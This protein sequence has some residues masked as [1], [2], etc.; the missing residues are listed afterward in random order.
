MT[1]T[2]KAQEYIDKNLTDKNITRLEITSTKLGEKLTD[3]LVIKDYIELE[4]I[5]LKEHKLTGLTVINCPKLKKINVRNNQLN[6]LELNDS[7]N[8]IEEIIANDNVLESLDLNNC[9]NLKKLII[10]DNPDLANINL[11]W[12]TIKHFNFANTSFSLEE[13]FKELKEEITSLKEKNEGFRQSLKIVDEA[14]YFESD[15]PNIA[16]NSPVL[17]SYFQFPEQKRRAKQILT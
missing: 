5:N 13:S 11:N 1:N 16:E 14:A 7:N 4:E 12:T 3:E 10:A 6:K 17:G 15:D 8:A 2:F 9:S